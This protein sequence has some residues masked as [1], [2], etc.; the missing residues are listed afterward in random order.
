MSDLTHSLTTILLAIVGVG[1]VAVLVARNANT[2]GVVQASAS[3]FSNALA[4]AQSP[5]TGQQLTINT[6]YPGD[7]GM[8]L[9]AASS[10]MPLGF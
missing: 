2:A 9:A 5:V 6:S 1:L 7:S 10:S 8:G 4:T 3:G